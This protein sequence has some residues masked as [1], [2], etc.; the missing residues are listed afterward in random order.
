MKIIAQGAQ[1]IIKAGKG[2]ILKDRIR[3]SYRI[4]AIDDRLRKIR[5]R[6][7]AKIMDQLHAI[8]FPV[9]HIFETDEKQSIWMEHLQGERLR[10]V[11]S[12]YNMQRLC[13]ELGFRIR[14][15]HDLHIIHG[16][17][18][19]SNF[20][21]TPRGKLYFIDFGLSYHSH[22]IEDKAV[23]LHLLRQALESKHFR[24]WKKAFQ[25]VLL[26]YKDR[27][28]ITRLRQVESRGRNKEKY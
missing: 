12:V 4:N 11:L 7:E 19:T 18:T 21:V 16:D 8:G 25:A 26:G 23:D 24:I 5:T 10:D 3:K 28:V 17:L 22:K 2:R 15:L 20:I 27:A 9:P 1:S 13:K 6:R 14:Q